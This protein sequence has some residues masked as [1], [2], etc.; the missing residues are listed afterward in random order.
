MQLNPIGL[1]VPVFFG[2]MAI[3]LLWSRRAKRQVYR[4]NDTMSDLTCGMGDQLINLVVGG[5][6]LAVYATVE[7]SVGWVDWTMSDPWAW[8]VGIVLVDLMYY[9]YHRFAH[10][11]NFGWAT[12]MVHHQSE[13]YNLA[14]AL[15]QPWFAQ[16]YAWLFYIPLAFLGVPAEVYAGSYAAN[17]LYQYWIH[18]KLIGRLGPLEWVMNTPSHHRVHHGTNPAYI[19]KNY[20]GMFIVWDRMFGTFE[21][22]DEEVVYGIMKPLR[23]WNPVWANV[24]PFV[25]LARASAAQD[26]LVDKL[27]MWVAEPGWTPDGVVHPP[28]PAP[29][30]GYDKNGAPGLRGY[31]V[32]H[33]VPVIA[34]TSLV[35]TFSAIW[36]AMWL[37]VGA[38]YILWTGFGWAWMLESKPAAVELERTRLV[39]VAITSVWLAG[40]V[41][42]PVAWSVAAAMVVVS[43][44]SWPWLSRGVM[45]PAG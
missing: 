45:T 7:S 27:H 2:L 40:V 3:E 24:G 16:F 9:A 42:G 39:A 32:A 5:L 35:I 31:I 15:R 33:L 34:A 12:H 43:A 37:A 21:P 1:A 29:G 10:R 8:V 22:E 19:D 30:R 13:E 18:T 26:R 4:L 36:P 11:V 44:V 6:T 41:G 23:S 14:V 20:A 28:F 25:N 38:S 17:L